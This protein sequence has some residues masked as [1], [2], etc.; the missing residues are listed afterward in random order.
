MPCKKIP[1]QALRS[2]ASGEQKDIYWFV[3]AATTGSSTGSTGSSG[4]N[5]Y[6]GV[7][8]NGETSF[9][10]YMDYIAHIFA[11]AL[12]AGAVLTIIMVIY[13]G[14]KYITSQGNP[15]ALNEAKDIIAGSLSGFVM[16]LLI[17]FILRMFNLPYF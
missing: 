13:A 10:S 15:T 17:F 4:G 7:A 1:D 6:T 12:K 14:Y 11:F 2:C 8:I 16:L 9:S 5:V 3:F